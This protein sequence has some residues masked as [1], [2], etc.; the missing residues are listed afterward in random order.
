MS[1]DGRVTEDEVSSGLLSALASQ[2]GQQGST[3]DLIKEIPNFVR[4][5]TEDRALS[6][7]REDEE[8]WEQQ[9]RNVINHRE[10][11]G[12]VINEGYVTYADDMMVLTDAGRA[13]LAQASGIT[14]RQLGEERSGF[15]EGTFDQQKR[16]NDDDCGV[17]GS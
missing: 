17:D 9:L 4:M 7:T 5:S 1:N 16:S 15:G 13:Y 11:A 10:T 12:N 8:L 3:G 2:P 6:L 14:D